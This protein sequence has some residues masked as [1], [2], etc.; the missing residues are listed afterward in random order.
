MNLGP[1]KKTAEAGFELGTFQSR[2]DR[3]TILLR[4]LIKQL[5]F[6]DFKFAAEILH[7]NFIHFARGLDQSPAC[8]LFAMFVDCYILYFF[9][10]CRQKLITSSVIFYGRSF[11][12]TYK[13]SSENPCHVRSILLIDILKDRLRIFPLLINLV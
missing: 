8:Y 9:G 12:M 1:S 4:L 10:I 3:S 7:F 13:M 2:D 5:K 11:P 6:S